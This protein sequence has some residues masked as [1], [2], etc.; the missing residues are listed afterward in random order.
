MPPAIIGGVIAGAGAIGSAAIGSS[1]AKSAA[2]ESAAASD[3]AAQL[4]Q[5]Q[6]QQNVAT[7]SPYVQAGLPATQQI[8]AL[9][10]IGGTQPG[11]VDWGAYV[12][13][14]QDALANWN[15]IKGTSDGQQ[16][17]GD[18]NAFGQ[19]H[20][21][22]DGSRRDLA[23]FTGT[24]AGQ[25]AAAQGA[26]DQF[27]NST[28]Y[29]W[30][31]KQGMNALNSGYAGA[32][33]IKSGAA[34]KGAVDYG[35]GQASQEF[36]NYLNALGTQQGVGLSAAGAQAGVG[37]NYANS[38]GNIYMQNGANQANASL[39]R[40]SALGGGLASAANIAGSVLAPKYN[41]AGSPGTSAF[42]VGALT[43]SVQNAFAANPGIF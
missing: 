18:I 7:L 9:L 6:Y 22:K 30:R 14:N 43:P 12:N 15:A 25:T 29:D 38:L 8:N 10:G 4:Q 33:T 35:Q 37:T 3:R 16:F 23:P 13:G 24:A 21:A 11:Q 32:G 5:Q 26:F 40:A 36:G 20:Y 39:A 42:T 41:Y 27:R 2:R 34:I 1:A 31:L 17:N 19:Y 28:G